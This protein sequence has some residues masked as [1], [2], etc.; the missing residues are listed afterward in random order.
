[1]VHICSEML[2]NNTQE[3]HNFFAQNFVRIGTIYI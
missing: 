3:T 1:V 2:E